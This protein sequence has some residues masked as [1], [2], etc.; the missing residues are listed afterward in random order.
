MRYWIAH[1]LAKAVLWLKRGDSQ[2]YVVLQSEQPGLVV[3]FQGSVQFVL[4]LEPRQC[5]GLANCL[6][7]AARRAA[8]IRESK[9]TGGR[10]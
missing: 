2:V 10:L 7:E 9:D 3:E 1:L 5:L 8:L 4:P 6:I